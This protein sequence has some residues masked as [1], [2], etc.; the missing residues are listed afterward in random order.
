MR[1]LTEANAL[2]EL[3]KGSE[4]ALQWFIQTYSPYVTTII[5]NI[6]GASMD[7]SDV[8]E[9]AADVFVALWQNAKK[10]YSVKGYLGTTARNMAKNKLRGLGY[11]LPLEEQIL[12]VDELSPE[13]QIEKRELNLAV[14]RAVLAM[15][16]PDKE[17]F[18][19]FYY[20]CQTMEEISREMQINLS[21]VKTKLRRGRAR[22][23]GAL[24]FYLT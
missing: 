19:R 24:V 14:K 7:V 20:Y 22:L 18:L 17:I 13:T 16:H 5:H 8:E 3:K 21:T 23:K 9:V 11:D 2:K 1:D 15:P 6:I 12:V 10:V 4:E